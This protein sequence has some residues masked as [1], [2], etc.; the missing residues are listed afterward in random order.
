MYGSTALYNRHLLYTKALKIGRNGRSSITQVERSV[1][2]IHFGPVLIDEEATLYA[3]RYEENSR[4]THQATA[5]QGC[6]M[7]RLGEWTLTAP[8]ELTDMLYHLQIV[9]DWV[10]RTYVPVLHDDLT[11]LSNSLGH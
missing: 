5:W 1:C 11:Q 10:K 8:D 6:N 2:I 3:F 4:E 7:S 9:V